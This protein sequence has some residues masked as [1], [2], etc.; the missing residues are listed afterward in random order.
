[1]AGEPVDVKNRGFDTRAIYAGRDPS[2]SSMPIYMANTGASFY[3]RQRNPTTDALE[4]CVAS[5]EGGAFADT[6]A[7][8][9]SAITQTFLTLLQTGD[10]LI[11]HRC[12]YDWVD[13]FVHH[14]A[15][16]LGIDAVQVD[17]RDLDALKKELQK[18]TQ[19]VHF[20]PLAN[21]SMDVLDVPEIIRIAH[22]AG[23]KVVVDNTW[24]SPALLRPLEF[25]ADIAVYACTKYMCGHGDAMGGVVI[26]NDEQFATDFQQTKAIFG[27]TMSPFN[28][29]NIL[30]G[31][32]TLSIRMRQ[33]G[34]NAF[35][36]AEF[37]MNH[38]AVA[39]T[40][41]PGLPGDPNHKTAKSLLKENGYGGMVSFVIAGGEPAQTVF[42]DALKLCKPWVSLGELF[43]L[44]YVR[45]TEERKGVP[46]G[47]I[48][49]SI[50][51]EN[52]EDVIED[53]GQ[54]LDQTLA[55]A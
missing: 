37:L 13:T 52:V 47:Y 33:H 14:S 24:L 42:R 1:M 46:E 19:V 34:E 26:S 50:G 43:T 31:L 10:R 11:T 4:D 20:E 9:I 25:G 15:P 40:R 18:P 3:S 35:R 23:A 44:V 8:G 45:W 29:Y 48:R 49:M 51:L 41:Y 5:L 39:E 36:V 6:A 32:S 30:R 55:K 17:M 28:A 16:R 2:C 38:P 53:L 21:P 7:C 54:A 12:V 27:G 22:E